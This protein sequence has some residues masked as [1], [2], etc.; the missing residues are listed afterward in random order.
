MAG[1]LKWLFGSS[2]ANKERHRISTVLP[3]QKPL[4]N[5]PPAQ[6]VKQSSAIEPLQG[7]ASNP[8]EQASPTDHISEPNGEA[9][10]KAYYYSDPSMPGHAY[11]VQLER[12]NTAISKRKYQDAAL[13]ARASFPLLRDWLV[14]PKGEGKR[15]N[16]R[17]PT[18]SQGG[19]MLAINEDHQ[20]LVELRDL[21][22]TFDHLSEYR[23]EANEHFRTLSLFR[24]IREIVSE[25]PGILQNKLKFELGLD[26]GKRVGVLVS[27]L[28]KAGQIRRAKESKTY[29][30]YP[31]GIEL[32]AEVA[33]QM[34][35]EPE[36]PGTHLK[37]HQPSQP[38]ELEL[39]KVPIVPL[40][41]SPHGWEGA[42]TLPKTS[43]A[44]ADPSE[45]WNEIIVE[46][47][48]P[49]ARPDPAFRRHFT[50]SNGVLSFDD[51]GK[52]NVSISAP[53][54]AA[55]MRTDLDGNTLAMAPLR[56][57]IRRIAVHPEGR[58]FAVLSKKGVLT[59]YN[60]NLQ[61]DFETDLGFAPELRSCLSSYGNEIDEAQKELRSVALSP[62]RDRYIFTFVD[63][64]WCVSR[65]GE[66]LWGLKMPMNE[67]VQRTFS[68]GNFG[69]ASQ[70]DEA[71]DV[72]G[73][74]MPVTPD[75]IRK[76]YRQ[77]V[78]E[79]HP[80][81]NPGSEERMKEVNVASERLTGLSPGDLDGRASIG[82]GSITVTFSTPPYPDMIG[83]VAFS[84][85]GEM[86][87]IGSWSG[88]VV[89]L[90]NTGKPV[91]IY[92]TRSALVNILETERF[93]YLA[94][95]TR[96]YVLKGNQLIGLADRSRKSDLLIEGGMVMM[97]EEKGVRVLT[98]DGHS[99]G[100]ALTKAPIRRAYFEGS[101][102]VIETRTHRGRYRGMRKAAENIH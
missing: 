9:D 19:T 41:P 50:T 23:D 32:P 3:E 43:E 28:D 12:L 100:V 78:R 88:R 80:D 57:D 62:S 30:L 21:V 63:E 53:A 42:P 35:V 13:A 17:I 29:A 6:S 37:S 86:A 15:L 98:A 74:K 82:E 85:T 48:A 27:Y 71:L 72:L 64:A 77:L 25:R 87:L 83:E 54:P 91:M 94:T 102:L 89:R 34:Y 1:F 52:S 49:A 16:I 11:F 33:A 79:L 39:N 93:L 31:S 45:A 90:D 81:L 18:L 75:E 67:P 96:L 68:I 56:R 55:V 61:V 36:S 73:L 76:R 46:P 14:N 99:L 2:T 20:G 40:P 66:V 97:V 7:K 5:K 58:G 69:T 59:T 47:I 38:F 22:M 95:A 60:E 92:E 65:K 51:L 26:D 4:H 10:S 84:G 101:D 24:K 8:W 70:I 44:F